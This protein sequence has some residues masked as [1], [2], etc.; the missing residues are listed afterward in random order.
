MKREYLVGLA[1]ASAS[2]LIA[3]VLFNRTD[4][5]FIVTSLAVNIGLLYAFNWL[6]GM[7]GKAQKSGSAEQRA[8]QA[9]DRVRSLPVAEAKR[10]TLS[11]LSDSQTFQMH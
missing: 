2:Q 1:L 6:V 8:R 3:W 9:I 7:L 11:L 10:R 4:P 5:R